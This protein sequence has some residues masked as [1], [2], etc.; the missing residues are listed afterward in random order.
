[1]VQTIETLK[2]KF[3]SG[4]FPTQQDYHDVFESFF[5]KNDSITTDE[6][7]GVGDDSDKTLTQI[8]AT[9][10]ELPEGLDE[11]IAKVNSFLDDTDLADE[12]INKWKEIESFLTGITDTETLTGLLASLKTEILAEQAIEKVASLYFSNTP[13]IVMYNGDLFN[14]KKCDAL[15]QGSFFGNNYNH[16]FEVGTKVLTIDGEDWVYRGMFNVPM[17]YCSL[18]R[19]DIRVPADYVIGDWGIKSEY[20]HSEYLNNYVTTDKSYISEKYNSVFDIY[21]NKSTHN[22]CGI[23]VSAKVI[24]EIFRD[25]QRTQFGNYYVSKNIRSIIRFDDY[26]ESILEEPYTSNVGFGILEKQWENQWSPLVMSETNIKNLIQQNIPE[27]KEYTAG[28]GIEISEDGVISAVKEVSNKR[29]CEIIDDL[30]NSDAPVGTIAMYGG[31]TNDKY[32]HGFIY[33]KGE[34]GITIEAG[35]EKYYLNGQ[36]IT[37]YAAKT[38]KQVDLTDAPNKFDSWPA[39]GVQTYDQCK[40][41]SNCIADEYITTEGVRFYASYTGVGNYYFAVDSDWST[42]YNNFVITKN[43]TFTEPMSFGTGASWT[44]LNVMNVIN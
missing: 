19:G 4:S 2:E 13:K 22:I 28:D 36:T 33:E 44:P 31:Q 12:T 39:W 3:K 21:E 14:L 34:G 37:G 38:G 7:K 26:T 40:D 27:Q 42:Y 17:L 10:P 20:G 15:V 1:M 5:S 8:L 16:V 32:T 25:C 11:F 6:I 29:F 23:I 30:D 43:G 24:I 35:A 41:Y 9:I 18:G